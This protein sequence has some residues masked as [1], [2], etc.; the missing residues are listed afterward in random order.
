MIFFFHL[1]CRF[2][3]MSK[4]RLLTFRE[5]FCWHC[6]TD[7]RHHFLEFRVNQLHSII[8]SDSRGP[9]HRPHSIWSPLHY[10]SFYQFE[11]NIGFLPE[12]MASVAC[13]KNGSWNAVF[14]TNLHPNLIWFQLDFQLIGHYN[15]LLILWPLT[16][17]SPC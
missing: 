16:M 12:T 9:S 2:Q 14:H 3:S 13:R 7:T 10:L 15:L 8:A 6:L 5:L 17:L 11:V 4:I 1:I